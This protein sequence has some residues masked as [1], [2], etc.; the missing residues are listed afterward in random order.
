MMP[1]ALATLTMALLKPLSCQAIA[2]ASELGAPFAPAIEPICDA[3][4]RPGAPAGAPVGGTLAAGAAVEVA[5]AI[6]AGAA[7]G[8][9]SRVPAM[10]KALGARPLAAANDAGVMPLAAAMPV[11]VSPGT[12]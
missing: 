4:R 6:A 1:R 5:G 7:A 8:I 11:S 3:D 2:V 12:T 9:F 10:T